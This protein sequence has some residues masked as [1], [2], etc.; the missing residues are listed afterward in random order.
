[1]WDYLNIDLRNRDFYLTDLSRG[2]VE[3]TK[4]RLN[5]VDMN[6]M[7]VDCE[8]IPFKD[9]FF[10]CIIANHMLFYLKNRDH[11]LQEIKRVLKTNGTFY[12]TTYS[13]KHMKE[14]NN[15]VQEYDPR[16]KLSNLN[17]YEQFGLENGHEILSD[18]FNRVEMKVYQD[19]LI[20][21]EVNPLVNYV[22][23]CHGNQNEIIGKNVEQFKT[24]IENKMKITGSIKIT[25]EACL[26]ICNNL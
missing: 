6:Y 26:F 9:Q 2:M 20:V 12:C 16:I 18:Y 13:Q 19:E 3:D 21:N 17:L 4:K 14:L 22:L 11:G 15:L 8:Q 5:N 23:S 1:M 7:V 24:F 10:D 25:K